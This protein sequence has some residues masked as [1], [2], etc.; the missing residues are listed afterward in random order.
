MATIRLAGFLFEN[1]FLGGLQR[2]INGNVRARF[3][4]IERFNL[5]QSLDASDGDAA[6]GI[7]FIH[8]EFDRVERIR[9]FNR[10][11]V[12][13][14]A[15][16]DRWGGGRRGRYRLRGRGGLRCRGSRLRGRGSWRARNYI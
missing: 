5:E 13:R 12:G 8:S 3:T 10:S 11:Q 16:N 6:L 2:V 1:E 9:A 15:K 4:G 14:H 7:D